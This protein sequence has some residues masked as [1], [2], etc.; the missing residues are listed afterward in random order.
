[1]FPQR[2]VRHWGRGMVRD[3][4]MRGLLLRRFVL[5]GPIEAF[6][7]L[8]PPLIWL[9][10]FAFFLSFW[11]RCIIEAFKESDSLKHTIYIRLGNE[12]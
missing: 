7:R 11:F 2:L 3:M 9:V 8:I 5:E 12:L 6:D 10:S 1:M 4:G